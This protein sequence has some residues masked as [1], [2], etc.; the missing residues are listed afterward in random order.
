MRFLICV[1]SLILAFSASNTSA[2]VTDDDLVQ[3]SGVIVTADSLRPLPYTSI[4]VVGSNVGTISDYYGY[5]SFVAQKNDSIQFSSIGFKK[6]YFV[7]PD[8]LSENRYSLIQMMQSD[9]FLLREA[10][11]YPWPSIE[12]FKDAFLALNVPD[13]DLERARKNLERQRLADIGEGMGMDGAENYRYQ[14]QQYQSQLYY[15][16]QAPPINIFNPIA[17]AKFIEA[18]RKGDFKKKE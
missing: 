14:M 7:I 16:G 13:D 9:T 1:F 2:Q 11:I 17:W 10:I 6:S 3:F 12:Q 8:S 18:W 5:F 15:S 4:I